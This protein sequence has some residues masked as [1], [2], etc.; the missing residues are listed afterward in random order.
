MK[1]IQIY[2]ELVNSL[3]SLEALKTYPQTITSL[4]NKLKIIVSD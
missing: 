2:K 1:E 3:S 4:L